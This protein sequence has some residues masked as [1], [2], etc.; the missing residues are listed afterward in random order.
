LLKTVPIRATTSSE[1]AGIDGKA[2]KI[3]TYVDIDHGKM[4]IIDNGNGMTPETLTTLLSS[5]GHPI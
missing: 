5:K 1:G 2:S 3:E 4:T